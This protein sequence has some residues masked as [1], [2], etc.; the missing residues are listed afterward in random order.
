MID[1][2]EV[3]FLAHRSKKDKISAGGNREEMIEKTT[4]EILKF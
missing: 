4:T 1:V 3:C 2:L